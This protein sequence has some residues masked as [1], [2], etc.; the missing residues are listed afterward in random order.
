[1]HSWKTE[2]YPENRRGRP[3]DMQSAGSY[4]VYSHEA[5]RSGRLSL[6][7]TG[8]Q[9]ERR[10]AQESEWLDSASEPRTANQVKSPPMIPHRILIYKVFP[11]PDQCIRPHGLWLSEQMVCQ[12]NP[13]SVL[14]EV[15]S[16]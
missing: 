6:P 8:F 14:S 13:V 2:N 9:A 11:K 7:A 15:R 1:M 10:E 12:V 16:E 4:L 5:G 3:T